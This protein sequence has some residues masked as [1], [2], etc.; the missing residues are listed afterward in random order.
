M[1]VDPVSSTSRLTQPVVIF[2]GFLRLI[3][4]SKPFGLDPAVVGLVWA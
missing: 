2:G 4:H 3:S 1:C